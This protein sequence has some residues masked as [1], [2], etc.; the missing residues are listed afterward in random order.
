M[1]IFTSNINILQHVGN[2]VV[3]NLS[4]YYSGYGDITGLITKIRVFNPTPLPANQSL[5]SKM[6]LKI[7]LDKTSRLMTVLKR[8]LKVRDFL[9]V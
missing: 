5:L 8:E 6:S 3:Y 1:I 4:S 2:A 7:K 9:P